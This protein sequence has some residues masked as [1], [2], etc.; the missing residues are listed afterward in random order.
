VGVVRSRLNTAGPPSLDGS[1]GEAL[2]AVWTNYLV[3][4]FNAEVSTILESSVKV[5]VIASGQSAAVSAFGSTAEQR[6]RIERFGVDEEDR[7]MK[8][9]AAVLTT[10][11]DRLSKRHGVI[12]FF[13]FARHPRHYLSYVSSKVTAPYSKRPLPTDVRQVNLSVAFVLDRSQSWL[14]AS[15]WDVRRFLVRRF[16]EH[17]L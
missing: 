1:G 8:P 13:F 2:A 15:S 14:V 7:R 4:H 11:V 6:A 12:L 5:F 9:F 10:D 16:R 3:R 17:D